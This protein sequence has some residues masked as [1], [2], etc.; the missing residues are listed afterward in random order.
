[1]KALIP[2]ALS[3][4]LLAAAPSPAPVLGSQDFATRSQALDARIARDSGE[5]RFA[6]GQE[7]ML[8][9]QLDR[10]RHANG[11]NDP[12]APAMLDVIDRQLAAVDFLLSRPENGGA[13]VVHVGDDV[14]VAMNDGNTYAARVSDVKKLA[15]HVG[16]M[17]IRGTQGIYRAKAPGTVGISVT[18][19][20]A[21]TAASFTVVILPA[22]PQAK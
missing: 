4:A 2:F 16:V 19:G 10:A 5:H 17:F 15:L 13:I 14:A 11:A 18:P 20:G 9:T 3:A 21:G 6:A 1:M 8:R 7:L 22:Q 12:M